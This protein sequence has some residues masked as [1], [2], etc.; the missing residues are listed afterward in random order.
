LRA[1]RPEATWRLL[2]QRLTIRFSAV[3]VVVA[4]LLFEALHYLA[5]GM[6]EAY[7]GSARSPRGAQPVAGLAACGWP[8]PEEIPCDEHL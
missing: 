2:E 3:A 8:H 5:A 7:R 6:S 4:G 1:R